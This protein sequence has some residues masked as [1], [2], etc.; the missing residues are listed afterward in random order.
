MKD[1]RKLGLEELDLNLLN[2]PDWDAEADKSGSESAMEIDDASC[3]P[4]DI[5]DTTEPVEKQSDPWL[6]PDC[7]PP[8]M[9]SN[10]GIFGEAL[11]DPTALVRMRPEIQFSLRPKIVAPF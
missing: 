2:R 5:D 6:D 4:M 10:Q 9:P 3:E 1:Q 8:P 11:M 7:I